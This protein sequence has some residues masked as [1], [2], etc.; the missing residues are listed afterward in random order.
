MAEPRVPLDRVAALDQV[1]TELVAFAAVLASYR[2]ALLGEGF[3]PSEA[4]AVVRD[5]Q[6]VWAEAAFRQQRPADGRG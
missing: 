3:S 5:F 6:R 4:L 1:A 2:A